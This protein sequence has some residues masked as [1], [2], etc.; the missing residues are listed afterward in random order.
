MLTPKP[1][2]VHSATLCVAVEFLH[3]HPFG[4]RLH[5]GFDESV[6]CPIE[7]WD[8]LPENQWRRGSARQ[9]DWVFNQSGKFSAETRLSIWENC[10]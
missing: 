6:V 4:P 5:K 2:Q 7:E 3:R 8:F 1:L 9:Y 10:P